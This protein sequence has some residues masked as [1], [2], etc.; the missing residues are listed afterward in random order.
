MTLGNIKDAPPVGHEKLRDLGGPIE[1]PPAVPGP[2]K[3]DP[4]G[5]IWLSTWAID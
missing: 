1:R 4:F 2:L 3:V 5:R